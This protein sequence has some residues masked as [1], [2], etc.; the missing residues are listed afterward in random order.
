[1]GS[2]DENEVRETLRKLQGDYDIKGVEESLLEA[3]LGHRMPEG[4]VVIGDG[5]L[6]TMGIWFSALREAGFK[7]AREDAYTAVPE[8][9][10]K[11]ALAYLWKYRVHGWQNLKLVDHEV[12]T[13]EERDAAVKLAS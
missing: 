3:V 11:E 12:C 8:E 7:P 4:Y 1:M 13:K 5:D 2:P 9:M 6:N 10:L